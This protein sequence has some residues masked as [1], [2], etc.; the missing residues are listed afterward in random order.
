MVWAGFPFLVTGRGAEDVPA[1]PHETADPPRGLAEADDSGVQ[2][3]GAVGQRDFVRAF[4]DH[5]GF[6]ALW[7]FVLPLI[8]MLIIG[9]WTDS[10]RSVVNVDF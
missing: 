3:F 1:A 5:D 4:A 6:L 8:F 2:V 7:F 9:N 10:C